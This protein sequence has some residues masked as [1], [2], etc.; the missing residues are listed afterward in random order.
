MFG[1]WPVRSDACWFI[2]LQWDLEGIYLASK[3]HFQSFRLD[4]W[5][6]AVF[7]T[8]PKSQSLVSQQGATPGVACAAAVAPAQE[9]QPD[10]VPLPGGKRLPLLGFGTYKVD[11]VDSIRSAPSPHTHMYS[12]EAHACPEV[13]TGSYSFS[14]H[15][16]LDQEG[17]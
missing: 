1:A 13:Q 7:G 2:G 8:G 17:C 15:A 16:H 12:A 5:C 11:G 14:R 3:L 10:A 6:S 9:R 4:S